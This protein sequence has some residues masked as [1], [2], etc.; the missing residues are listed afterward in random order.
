MEISIGTPP[1]KLSAQA[2]TGSDLVWA[3]CGPCASCTPQGS[4]SFDPTKSTSFSKLAC[5]DPLCKALQSKGGSCSAGGTE[6]DYKYLY[7]LS[8]DHYTQ[9]YMRRETFTIGGDAVKGVG[10]GCTNMSDG[11]YGTGSG[12]VGLGRGLLSLVSQLGV[13][14]F[15]YCLISDPSK[16]SPL[17][18]GSQATL[19]GAGV[20]STPLLDSLNTVYPV[21]LKGIS[22]GT[23][24][25]PGVGS[26]ARGLVFDSGT[27]LTYLAQPAYTAARK[28]ILTQTSLRKVADRGRFEACFQAPEDGDISSA[29]PPMVLH[30]D[31]ADMNLPVENYFQEVQTGVIC[32]IVQHSPS[33]SIIGNIM[34]MNYH[35]RYDVENMVLSFQQA[36]CDSL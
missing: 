5:S 16:A 7:G 21:N 6:C 23:A 11:N 24:T 13:G 27:T 30:F 9:G 8:G 33:V 28:S 25:T 35:I 19:T 36:N 22:I 26:S 3:K 4:P 29:V 10:F 14:A 32:W 34:Q 12:L 18:F 1:Q 31:G 20:Q 17:L 15:S 2:D